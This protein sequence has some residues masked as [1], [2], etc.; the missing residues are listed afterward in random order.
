MGHAVQLAINALL[1]LS[2]PQQSLGILSAE[3]VCGGQSGE[4][5]CRK[6]S[7]RLWGFCRGVYVCELVNRWM[8]VLDVRYSNRVDN[9]MA[10]LRMDLVPLGHVAKEGR[11][12]A[13]EDAHGSQCWIWNTSPWRPFSGRLRSRD[14]SLYICSQMKTIPSDNHVAISILVLRGSVVV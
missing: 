10:S 2:S 11:K 3:D 5:G 14:S 13:R 9:C 12:A 4:S 1:A 8:D 6:Y 7:R